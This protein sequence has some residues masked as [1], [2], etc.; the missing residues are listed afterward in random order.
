MN[1]GTQMPTLDGAT[2]WLNATGAGAAAQAVGHPTLVHFW[3]VSCGICKENMARVAEW[4]DKLRE[5]GLRVIAVHMPRYEEETDTEGVREAMA[6][7]KMS[8]PCAVDNEHALRDAFQN[9]HGYVPAYY[10]FDAQGRLKSF[11]AGERGPAVVA[12]ALER[13]LANP[14]CR[15]CDLNL[16]EEVLYCPNCGQPVSPQSA[17]ARE[18]QG[19]ARETE[20]VAHASS[21]DGG[22]FKGRVLDRKYELMEQL[23]EGGMSVVY[24]AR[25]THIGDEV[26]VKILR[27]KMVEAA[28]SVER[29]RREARAAAML[30]H[31]NVVTIH[32]FGE[33]ESE[34]VPAYIVMELVEGESLRQ[35]LKRE[36]ALPLSRAVPLMYG[37]CAGVGVAH[38]REIIHRDIKPDNVIVIPADE[39]REYEISKVVDF[40]IARLRD[41][42]A[43]NSITQTGILMGTPYYMSPEQCLGEQLDTRSDVYSLGAMFYEMLAGSPPFTAETI[44]GIIAKHL[45][46][47]PPSLP[48]L[49]NIAPGI[50]ALIRRALAKAPD[51]RPA[52]ASEFKRELREIAQSL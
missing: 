49:S 29:F 45:Y 10:L 15:D 6:S 43:K 12:P 28:E 39:D 42:A 24:R 38:R 4:R 17:K 18:T 14:Y 35:L 2:E 23:G 9:E 36:G 5:K 37:I 52:D 50:E 25:R 40:G 16:H 34:D 44:T 22:S 32:D 46:A 19:R 33:T 30:R 1:I 27:H 20:A 41:M 3:S 8:E 48:R 11:A 13:L 7:L 26:A 51:E 21:S 31:P 47:E